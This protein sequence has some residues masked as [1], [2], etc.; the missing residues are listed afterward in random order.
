MYSSSS[1]RKCGI[2][3]TACKLI[4]KVLDMVCR[5]DDIVVHREH[6]KNQRHIE[7]TSPPLQLN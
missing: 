4:L 6:L 2:W 5:V 1:E 7:R 3:L